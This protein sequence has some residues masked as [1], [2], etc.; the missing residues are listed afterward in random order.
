MNFLFW[1][2]PEVIP[3][4]ALVVNPETITKSITY[5]DRN[6]AVFFGDG[7]SATIISLTIPGC[8]VISNYGFDSRQ[9]D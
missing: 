2:H 5:T 1:M 7:A 4:Y 9:F 3:S 8:G 6:N